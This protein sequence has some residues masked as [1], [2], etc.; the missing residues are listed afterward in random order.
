MQTLSER[1]R[2]WQDE[3]QRQAHDAG[4]DVVRVSTDDVQTAMALSEFV[5]ERRLRKM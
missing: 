4:L 5:A 1:M 2:S 3:V